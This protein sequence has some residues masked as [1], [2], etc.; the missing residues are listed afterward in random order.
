MHNNSAVNSAVGYGLE[1][2]STY[3][4]LLESVEELDNVGGSADVNK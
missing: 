2:S 1:L 3:S 4:L